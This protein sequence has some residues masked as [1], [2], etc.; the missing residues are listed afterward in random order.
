MFKQAV[1][2]IGTGRVLGFFGDKNFPNT[3]Q[4]KGLK[5]KKEAMQR[6]QHL[7]LALKPKKVYVC[8]ELGLSYSIMSLLG[9]L[10]I[11]YSVVN[12]YCGYFDN[13][14]KHSKLRM[15]MG[16]ENSSSVITIAEKRPETVVDARKTVAEAESFIIDKSEVLI[17]ALGNNPNQ[18][19]LDTTEKLLAS[20][21]KKVIAISYAT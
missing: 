8:P 17:A 13:I 16:L 2:D 14:P 4:G 20:S 18:H 9:S 12:P 5:D 3:A 19:L 11:P 7:L 15:L 21:T 10:G 1:S 6:L